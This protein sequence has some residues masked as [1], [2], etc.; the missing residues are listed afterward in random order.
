M[1]LGSGIRDPGSCKN[2]FRIQ[3]Q[4]GTGSRIRI[5]NTAKNHYKN[6][7]QVSSPL[8]PRDFRFRPSSPTLHCTAR[9][10]SNS[11]RLCWSAPLAGWKVSGSRI[12]SN[13]SH[14][15]SMITY[16]PCKIIKLSAVFRIR[17]SFDTDPV[18]N[19]RNSGYH[20]T[21]NSQALF[22][23]Y[24]TFKNIQIFGNSSG[25]ISV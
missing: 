3:G 7:F 10:M 15:L 24:Q 13:M 18:P 6:G 21:R 9:A 2:L 16:G 14:S 22:P 25:R 12:L 17:E 8:L 23:K 20:R 19:I 11:W 1:I 5:C 4:K